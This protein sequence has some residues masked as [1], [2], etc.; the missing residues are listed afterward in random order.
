MAVSIGRSKPPL[1]EEFM[2]PDEEGEIHAMFKKILEKK[3]KTE[4]KVL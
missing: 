4:V 1:P 3:R 2:K